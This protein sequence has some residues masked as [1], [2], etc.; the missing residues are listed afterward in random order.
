MNLDIQAILWDLDGVIV[1]TGE[2]HYESWNRIL[3]EYN[4]PFSRE[5]FTK[6]FGMNNQLG[7][8]TLIGEQ[9]ADPL[10][11]EIGEKKEEL[12]RELLHDNLVVLPGV[13]HWLEMASKV[14]I[15][16][17]LATSAPQENIDV[18][19]Q[20]TQIA[21]YFQAVVS[22][23]GKPGKPDPWV[24]LEAAKKLNVPPNKCLVV[25]DSIMGIAAAKSAGAY[26]LAVTTTNSKDILLETDADWVFESLPISFPW[27][28]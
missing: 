17:A 8:T 15:K 24:F 4:I 10:W 6:I 9:A 27:L 3:P 25:E 11:R 19:F 28:T 5:L 14:G 13:M 7:V 22:A 12:F 26:C 21:P 23:Y 2:Q 18:T 1:D 20:E 16:Q